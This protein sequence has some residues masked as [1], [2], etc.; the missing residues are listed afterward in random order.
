VHEAAHDRVREAEF[1]GQAA[2][3]LGAAEDQHVGL[4]LGAHRRRMRLV[5]D[6]AHLADV[7]ARLQHR[8]DHLATARIG[9]S[10]RARP[11]SRMNSAFDFLPCSTTISPR[12]KRRLTTLSAMPCAW[13]FRQQREQRHAP[14]QVEVREHGHL[15]L[16]F[17]VVGGRA[18]GPRGLVKI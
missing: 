6:Q 13:S 3:E 2:R 5:V 17:R 7:V 14:D 16:P 1:S 8:E 10:T 4:H 15:K 11:V 12:R 9:V 18:A